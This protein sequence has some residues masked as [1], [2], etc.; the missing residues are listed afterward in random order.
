MKAKDWYFAFRKE[1]ELPQYSSARRLF[2]K[3][4]LK[5]SEWTLQMRELF[6]NLAVK[7]GYRVILEAPFAG[8]THRDILWEK[9][10]EEV[11]IEHE[12]GDRGLFESEIPKL[13]AVSSSLRVLVAY[14]AEKHLQ[15][16]A[17][18]IEE[19]VRERLN[20]K[21]QGQ[22]FEILVILG[23]RRISNPSQYLA[24]QF[25]PAYIS[26]PLSYGQIGL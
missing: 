5:S 19:F 13:M 6:S 18:E 26:S 9:D 1:A 15:S 8:G 23:P 20:K 21:M 25:T 14:P 16:R 22:A 24:W 10:G 7:L 4:E 12:N 3:E 2:G 17:N 11:Y